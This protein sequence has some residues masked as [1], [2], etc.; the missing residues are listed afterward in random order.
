MHRDRVKDTMPTLS[1]SKASLNGLDV[2]DTGA[3]GVAEV[4][5]L[6]S[7]ILK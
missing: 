5:E 1:F 2:L 3:G 6:E 7:D 4:V